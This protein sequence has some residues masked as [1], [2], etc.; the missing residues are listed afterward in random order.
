MPHKVTGRTSC[1]K[2]HPENQNI[3][4]RTLQWP[5]ES[6][7]GVGR[8]SSTQKTAPRFW[9]HPWASWRLP[10]AKEEYQDAVRAVENR[11][12]H[13]LVKSG[14]TKAHID[15]L[16]SQK[17]GVVRARLCD[18]F[19][20]PN[21]MGGE[22]YVV[23]ALDDYGRIVDL[24]GFHPSMLNKFW[25]RFGVATFIGNPLTD[26]LATSVA[27]LIR[28]GWACAFRLDCEAKNE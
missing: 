19:Y 16:P 1:Q 6:R 25:V 20:E 18:G 2:R 7:Q 13:E 15:Q 11:H 10:T 23:P 22:I 26:I 3:T 27:D 5:A 12:L 28:S 8:T 21:P 17:I 9:S 24:V 14:I 4:S